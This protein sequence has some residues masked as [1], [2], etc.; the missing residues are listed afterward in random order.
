MPDILAISAHPDDIELNVAGTLLKA[1]AAGRTAA[2]CDLTQGERGSRGSM[3]LRAAE[4]RRANRVLGIADENRWNL[5]IPDGNIEVTMEN[6][7]KVVR[8]IRYFRPKVLLFSWERDRHTDHEN[9]HRLVRDACFD[10]G[11]R[12]VVTEWNGQQQEPH[13]PEKMYCFFHTYERTPDFVIDISDYIEGKLAAVAAYSSQFT[14]PGHH[15][16][17][18]DDT[19]P[20]TFISGTDFIEAVLGRM[21]HWGFMIGTRYGEA[22]TTVSGPLKVNDLLDTI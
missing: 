15:D 19:E 9:G 16:E 21:R 8:A 12:H 22:F 7:L 2:V 18:E 10:A 3:E 1:I 11:L 14:V 5:K 6:R 13:R 20:R 4:T 17:R